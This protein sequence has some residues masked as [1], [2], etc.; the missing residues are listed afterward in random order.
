MLCSYEILQQKN[1]ISHSPGSCVRNA[2][3]RHWW[4]DRKNV[5]LDVYVFSEIPAR[6]ETNDCRDCIYSS[7]K[8]LWWTFF[9]KLHQEISRD[10]KGFETSGI[11]PEEINNLPFRNRLHNSGDFSHT[12]VWEVQCLGY[13]ISL[14]TPHF[15]NLQ[16][17]KHRGAGKVRCLCCI[18]TYPIQ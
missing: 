5:T 16:T 7:Q 12:S 11:Q 3:W 9:R 18:V 1:G 15:R 6:P 4:K 10:E 17:L 14:Q 2:D 13:E 8:N